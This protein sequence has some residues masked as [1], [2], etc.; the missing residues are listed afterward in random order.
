M[1]RETDEEWKLSVHPGRVARHVMN[2]ICKLR[3]R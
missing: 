2:V 3:G 1:T